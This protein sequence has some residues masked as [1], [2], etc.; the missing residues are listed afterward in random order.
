LASLNFQA[1]I[2]PQHFG[3]P[4]KGIGGS[5]FERNVEE[6]RVENLGQFEAEFVELDKDRDG[7]INGTD[8]KEVFLR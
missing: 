5:L 2:S 4:K 6:W 3:G 7:L 8:V 1:P